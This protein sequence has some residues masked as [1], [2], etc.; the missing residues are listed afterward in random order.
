MLP[1]GRSYD[2]IRAAFRW[3]VPE[4]YN[5]GVDCCDRW[6][7]GSGRTALLHLQADGRLHRISF[8]ALKADSNRLANVLRARGIGAG[9]RVGV[10]LPQLPE[11]AV[12]HL[13]IYKLGAIAVPL[14]Q[15]FQEQ[16]LEFRLADS[17]AAALV[18]DAVG[19]PKL[20][21]IR[22]R[23]PALRLVLSADGAA[24]GALDLHGQMARASDDFAPV[25]TAADD[26]AIIIYTSGTTGAPKGALH[27]HRVL[28]GHLP[29]VEMP[30]DLFPK[31]GD[32]FWTPADWAWVGGLF[33]VLL[34]SLHHGVPVL[35]HRMA[36]F[37]PEFAFRLMARHQ[38]R[39]AFLPPTALKLMRG[40]PRA[41]QY[42]AHPR[43]IGSGGETLG[44]ELLDWGRSAFGVTINEFYG[45]TECNLVVSSCAT[46]MPTR[47]GWMGRAV[48]GHEVAVVDPQGHP[49]L[50][51]EV[52]TIAIRQP[53]PVMFLGY[54]NN[55]AATA[56]KFAGDWLLTGDQ[57][58]MDGEGWFRFIGRDDDVITSAGYRIGPGEIEDC[59]LRHPAVAM[60]AVIGLPDPVRTEAVTAVI[61]PAPGAATGPDLVAE[62]QDQVRTRLAAHCYPRRVIFE[63]ALPLTATGKVMRGELRRRMMQEGR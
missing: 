4:R 9:D 37:D 38:V 21:G 53:D 46:L 19:L 24:E 28:L 22:D 36:K 63:D 43:S 15:L 56:A 61:V 35:A 29:G 34:P 47:P 51:G 62:L 45:Q 12:A 7:D 39:N 26:P 50:P 13:A 54:W 16:A 8:D 41:A 60:A 31:P 27:A 42:G 2:A 44:A 5:L 57:G 59:L 11:A 49:L 10:L 25:D 40:V 3:R 1:K 23:L 32:L 20:A 6:A 18:T 17:G 58:V 30:Q 14:F 55:P 33:D 48:P 52:G